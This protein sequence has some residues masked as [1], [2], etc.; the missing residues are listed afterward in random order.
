VDIYARSLTF[1]SLDSRQRK[2]QHTER[3]EEEKKHYTSIITE[4]E[5][6]LRELRHQ[7]AQWLHEKDGWA[8]SQQRY[9]EY[10]DTLVMEKEEMVRCHTIETGE[11]RKKNTILMEQLQRLESTAMSTAPS[12]TGF[13]ADFSD[14]DHLT[15]D[16]SPWDNFSIANDFSLESDPTPG[17][18]MAVAPK[19]PKAVVKDDDKAAASGF[20]LML[21]LC[22]AWVASRGPMVS[23]NVLPVMPED[24][25]VASATVLDHIYKD[26]GIQL[27][28][29]PCTTQH[30]MGTVATSAPPRERK[31]TLSAFEIASLSTAPLD[32]LHHQLTVANG[33][34]LRD[35]AFSL[36]PSQY[37]QLS[38]DG[39]YEHKQ[40]PDFRTGRNIQNVLAAVR[41]ASEGSAADVY[42]RSLMWEKIPKEVVK[43][44]AR[45]IAESNTNPH[46]QWKSE[47]LN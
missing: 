2:K 30:A 39:S 26:A 3:L 40:A 19:H 44:F 13:S 15:M 17:T 18:S 42:T 36:T 9:K 12:S 45:M 23:T 37:N 29:G 38:S 41:T 21:L 24:M 32:T 11:L 16:S 47:P 6:E 1:F 10:V 7:E 22:G 33:H 46:T 28:E 8:T 31:T 35:Q 14:F 34:Q 20:L 43:D 4:L 25:R 27:Q 5:E